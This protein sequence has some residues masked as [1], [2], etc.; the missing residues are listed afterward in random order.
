MSG[1]PCNAQ[2]SI[3][4]QSQQANFETEISCYNK[5]LYLGFCVKH[6]S[7]EHLSQKLQGHVIVIMPQECLPLQPMICVHIPRWQPSSHDLHHIGYFIWYNSRP[8]WKKAF[9]NL[10]RVWFDYFDLTGWKL[11]LN[12]L[13]RG[14]SLIYS[15][16]S[17]LWTASSEAASPWSIAWAHSAVMMWSQA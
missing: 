14:F 1:W 2:G 8:D 3:G 10:L 13:F 12:L 5:H 17:L 6:Y 9:F 11:D 7:C 4:D 16:S 15:V